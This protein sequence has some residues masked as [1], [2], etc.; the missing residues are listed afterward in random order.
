MKGK[1]ERSLGEQFVETVKGEGL[2]ID[3]RGTQQVGNTIVTASE[4]DAFFGSL[5]SSIDKV[6]SRRG[7]SI[8]GLAISTRPDRM[9]TLKEGLEASRDSG[10]YRLRS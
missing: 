1:G 8:A 7:K 2:V 4:A 5:A 10:I 3:G 9:A 6:A